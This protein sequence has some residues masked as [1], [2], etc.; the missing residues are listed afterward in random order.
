MNLVKRLLKEEEG[1]G[2]IE[3]VIIAAFISIV[4]IVVIKAIGPK[5]N[6]V[7]QNVNSSL[8]TTAVPA[9]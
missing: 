1:Q 9:T 2:M 6:N 3:Y 5:I 7:W 8:E 4:A